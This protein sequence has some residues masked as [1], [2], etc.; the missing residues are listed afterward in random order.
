[1]EFLNRVQ[2]ELNLTP[3]QHERIQQIIAEGQVRTK[4]MW[5]P[6]AKQMRQEMQQVRERIRAELTPEQRIRFEELLKQRP[7]RKLIDPPMLD[8][9]LRDPRRPLQPPPGN[10]PPAGDLQQPLPGPQPP[11]PD[12]P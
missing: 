9:R 11:A 12:N 3:V 2:R 10:P 1:M 5:E 8:R 4:E 7:P 6:V